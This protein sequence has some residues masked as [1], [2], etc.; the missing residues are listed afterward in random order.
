MPFENLP[1]IF[2]TKLDG[3]LTIPNTNGSPIVCVIGTASQGD[4][5]NLFTVT[6]L[7]DAARA[8][9]K[10]GTLVRGMYETAAAGATN[11]RLFRIGATAATLADIGDG[12][13]LETVAKDD[14]TGSDFKIWFTASSGRLRVYRTSDNTLVYDSGDGTPESR[15]DLGEVT[16]S[17]T[18]TG[19][20]DVGTSAETAVDLEDVPGVD[21]TTTFTAGTDG[22]NITRMELYQKLD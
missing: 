6:R 10:N 9:A 17:G 19:G 18:A 2:D 7:N 15:V 13:F 1:G 4:S 22:L 3:N 12:L 20:V 14:S 16:V 5:E 8:F 11:I 21:P